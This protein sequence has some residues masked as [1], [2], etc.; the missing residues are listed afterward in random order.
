MARADAALTHPSAVCG[1]A[2][3]AFVV[4]VAHAV[5]HGDGARAA[6]DAALGWA[7]WAGAEPSV[8][9]ALEAAADR[10]PICDQESQG[11]VLHALQNA[12]N[13]LL[14]APS[15]EAGVVRTGDVI[16]VV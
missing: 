2:T 10:A 13:E 6:Y 14:H 7:R 15:L 12:F 4:A 3:A 5:A 1:D 9:T 16:A 11:W 8:V